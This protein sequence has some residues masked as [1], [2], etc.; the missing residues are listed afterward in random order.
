MRFCRA[1]LPGAALCVALLS[2]VAQAQ[3]PTE[4]SRDGMVV[5]AHRLASE[6]GAGILRRGG[7]AVDAAVATGLAL[8]VTFPVAGNIGGGGF[9]LVRL[10]DGRTTVIDYRETAPAA[11]TRDMYLDPDGNVI[12]RAS[13]AGYRAPGVP[14]TIAGLAFAFEKY[15]SGKVSWSDVVEPA[16]ALAADGFPVSQAFA[17]ELVAN[18]A[19]LSRFSETS[20]IFLRGGDGWKRGDQFTQPELA[21]TLGRIQREGPREFYEGETAKLLVAEMERGGGLITAA[22]LR[23]YRPVEREPLRGAYRG[24]E[25][26]TVPPPSSGGVAVLQMLGMLEPFNITSTGPNSAATVHVMTEVMRRVFCDRA[27][28]LGDPAFASVPVDRL[29]QPEYLRSRMSDFD[30]L[31]AT[32]S[33]SLST[34]PALP[35]AE[36]DQTTHFSVVDA[37]GNI[38]SNT[39][40]LNAGYGSGVTVAGAGFLLN[41]EM[42]DFTSKPGVK[43]YFGLLQGEAN[44]IAP[45]KRPLSSMT[46]TIVAKDG[47]PFLVVG[48]PG[49]PTIINTV[50][51]I[52]L[53]VVDHHMNLSRAVESPRVHHQWMPDVLNYEPFGLSP[54][55]IAALRARGHS[56]ALR[57]VYADDADE[58]IARNQGAAM[59]IMIDPDGLLHGFADPRG[60][61]AAAIGK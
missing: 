22:D 9:M 16:R 55:T 12:P 48:S 39:Y 28:L 14:G 30:P 31:Q 1:G 61:D 34:G 47:R 24:H 13:T 57:R 20:R 33:A 18:R 27:E 41:N 49:G 10:S 45:G 8:A 46:P 26:V 17:K 54:D 25:I 4:E 43:N 19:T 3:R 2:P 5:S 59:C 53:N 15:G 35:P 52:I 37:A 42:D 44:A 56:L 21:A 58:N 32:P 38:V 11:A 40:T 50:L 7:N 60:H 51:G 6:A 23:G 29:L 36:S